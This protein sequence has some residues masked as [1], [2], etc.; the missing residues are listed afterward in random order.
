MSIRVIPNARESYTPGHLQKFIFTFGVRKQAISNTLTEINMR[1]RA[2]Q[3]TI[4]LET[5]TRENKIQAGCCEENIH[6]KFVQNFIQQGII[7]S[8]MRVVLRY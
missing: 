4:F 7:P 6:K 8:R 2:L 5:A 3:G 1:K